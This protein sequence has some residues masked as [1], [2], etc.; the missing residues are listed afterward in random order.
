MDLINV[1]ENKVY[2]SP[3]EYLLAR[4]ISKVFNATFYCK[5]MLEEYYN[6]NKNI[7]R[8]RV[9]TLHNNVDTSNLLRSDNAF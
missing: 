7:K 6:E 9:V 1:I 2:M 3:P 8:K 4:N 5:R